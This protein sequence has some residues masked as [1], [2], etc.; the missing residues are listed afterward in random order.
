MSQFKPFE[1]DEQSFSVGAG[2]GL[3]VQNGIELAS[4]WGE[5]KFKPDAGGKQGAG[6]LLEVLKGLAAKLPTGPSEKSL[7][8]KKSASSIVVGGDVDLEMGKTGSGAVEKAVAALES[9]VARAEP[10]SQETKKPAA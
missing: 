1:N 6:E 2:E 10:A 4:I 7:W 5:A 3:T 8:V 9:F